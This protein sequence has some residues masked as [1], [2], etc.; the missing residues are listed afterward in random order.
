MQ[1]AAALVDP[2]LLVLDEPFS[3]LDP[4]GVATITEVPAPEQAAAGVAVV[5]SSHQLDLVEEVCQDV[6]I[7]SGRRIVAAGEI[8]GS[9]GVGAA[10]PRR[11]DR[12]RW[13]V[14]AAGEDGWTVME[15]D[16]DSVRLLV[17]ERVDLAAMLASAQARGD[18]RHF[19]G[20]PR[21]SGAVHGRHRRAH[22]C[23]GPR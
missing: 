8:D 14:V 1:L 3:G 18:V 23:G 9:S 12:R 4:L 22:A 6:A 15:R 5:F 19:G 2:V 10:A 17:D 20:P 21:L 16:G 13:L 11:G 7:I